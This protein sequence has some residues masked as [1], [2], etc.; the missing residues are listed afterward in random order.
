MLSSSFLRYVPRHGQGPLS[1]E[2][3]RTVRH[4]TL[5][6][7]PTHPWNGS[8][9]DVPRLHVTVSTRL[10]TGMEQPE[11]HWQ[12]TSFKQTPVG[13]S[14][15]P[16]LHRRYPAVH[17]AKLK[18]DRTPP[19]AAPSS[20]SG[21]FPGIHFSRS[22]PGCNLSLIFATTERLVEPRGFN[23][24]GERKLAQQKPGL[25]RIGKR[26]ALIVRDNNGGTT[27]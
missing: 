7:E 1:R 4:C 2:Y 17:P 25:R 11:T 6:D 20:P 12:S 8:S 13:G 10:H 14:H 3:S 15:H 16:A 22:S 5:Q 24:F 27:H 9:Y 21:S 26:R 19:N 18:K 23:L